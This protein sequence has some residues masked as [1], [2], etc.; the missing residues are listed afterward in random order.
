MTRQLNVTYWDRAGI[1]DGDFYGF[2]KRHFLVAVFV[3]GAACGYTSAPF[4]VSG[5]KGLGAGDC[6]LPGLI[7]S[8]KRPK[9]GLNKKVIAVNKNRPVNL[10]LR[11]IKFPLPAI[12]S[13]LHRVSGVLIFL[14]IPIL[15]WMLG[16]SLESESAFASLKDCLDGFFVTLILW[17]VLGVL[18]YH[19]VAGIRHL[20]MDMGWGES[21]EGGAKGAKI[22][23]VAA[24]VL[25]LFIGVWL[26]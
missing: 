10:D 13:I 21:L 2:E 23:F 18:L 26:W 7:Y 8:K 20:M 25:I 19:F 3:F 1:K 4:G 14:S 6:S 17:G 15:L 12:V 11:T 9:M 22:V 16:Q 24:A 5:I